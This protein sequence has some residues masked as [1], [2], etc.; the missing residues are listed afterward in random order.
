MTRSYEFFLG[1]EKDLTRNE[2]EALMSVK[3]GVRVSESAYR[4]LEANDLI[5]KGLG[6]W[7]L[8][9][10]GTFRLAAGK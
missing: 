2:V 9:Q 10:A 4:T 5:E 8:T 3:A 6:G 1:P 7:K